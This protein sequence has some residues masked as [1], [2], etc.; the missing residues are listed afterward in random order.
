MPCTAKISSKGQVTLPRQVRQVL[1]TN[2]VEFEIVNGK[3]LISPVQSVAGALAGYASGEVSL[4]NVRN[5][6]WQEVADERRK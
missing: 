1:K 2:V 6:V 4:D 3:V 5:K